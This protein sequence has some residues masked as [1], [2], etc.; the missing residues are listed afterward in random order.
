MGIGVAAWSCYWPLDVRA[1]VMMIA[2]RNERLPL[3]TSLLLAGEV[4]VLAS[5]RH[6][7]SWPKTKEATLNAKFRLVQTEP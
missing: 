5:A 6:L 1:E 4:L 7:P 3:R 2:G